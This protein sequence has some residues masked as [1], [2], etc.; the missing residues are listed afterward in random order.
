MHLFLRRFPALGGLQLFALLCAM[1]AGTQSLHAGTITVTTT[2]DSG[3]GS[4][5]AAIAAA[6]DGDTIQFD[7]ALN[8]Q[9]ITLTS[10]ELVIDKN[11]TISGP[12]P[13]LLAVS[14]GSAQFRIFH[15]MSGHTV[16][17]GG[18][19]ISHGVGTGGGVL[20]EQA[21]LTLANCTVSN[22]KGGVSPNGTLAGG[23][24]ND[25]TMTITDSI[26]SGNVANEAGGI[27]NDG[28]MGLR[29]STVANNRSNFYNQPPSGGSAGGIEIRA[30]W[31]SI[32]ARSAT[33]GLT[34]LAAASSTMA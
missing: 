23:I 16:T 7:A 11:V 24:F 32:T 10:A 14:S 9:T 19:T 27:F 15:V 22:N 28:T 34:F 3:A 29:N 30:P 20:N 1:M 31:R 17:I 26:V 2:A 12:G 8:G 13:N 4:L 6:S 5:R 21:T 18:L 33:T 25:G